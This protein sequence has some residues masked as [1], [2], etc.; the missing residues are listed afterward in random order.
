MHPGQ[1]AVALATR[2]ILVL[3]ADEQDDGALSDGGGG[4]DL[5]PEQ[6]G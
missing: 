2:L 3:F 5:T 1:Y 4:D 6:S